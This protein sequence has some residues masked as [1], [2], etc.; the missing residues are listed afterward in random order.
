MLNKITKWVFYAFSFLLPLTFLP[1]KNFASFFDRKIFLAIFVF[2]LFGA[3]MIKSFASGG[4]K[5]PAGKT[6]KAV[7]AAAAAFFASAIFSGIF[8]ASFFGTLLQPDS[9][10]GFGLCFLIFFLSAAILENEKEVFKSIKFFIAG[11]SILAL[12]FLILGGLTLAGQAVLNFS[13]G[14]L[15]QV[16][17]LVFGGGL[18]ALIAVSTLGEGNIFNSEAKDKKILN[19][20]LLSLEGILLAAAI[21]FVD[22][23]LTW[24]LIIMASIVILC[25]L[26]I[27]PSSKTSRIIVSGVFIAALFLFFFGLPFKAQFDY[28]NLPNGSLSLKVAQGTLMESPKNFFF[29]SGMASFPNQFALHNGGALNGTIFSGIIFEQSAFGFLTLLVE[30]GILGAIAFLILAGVFLWH[31]FKLMT[32]SDE[33]ER[34]TLVAFAIAYYFILIFFFFW[35][36]LGLLALAFWALGMFAAAEKQKEIVF[37]DKP[38]LKKTGAALIALAGLTISVFAIFVSFQQYRANLAAREANENYSQG[39]ADK[40]IMQ[41]RKA[42]SLWP[43][44]DYY[45]LLSNL[46]LQKA[47]DFLEE[48]EGE[49]EL[50]EEDQSSLLGIA[51]QAIAVA[52]LACELNPK[53]TSNWH[54]LGSVYGNLVFAVENAGQAG[55]DAYNKAAELYPQSL[56]AVLGRAF[57]YEAR[58]EKEKAIEEYKKYLSLI[59]FDSQE[60]ETAAIKIE[61]L[62]QAE[63]SSA[64]LNFSDENLEEPD[65][66]GGTDLPDSAASAGSEK[67]E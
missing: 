26:L 51:D 32:T 11:A 5:Y 64:E 9:F 18:T 38:E 6:S 31:G 30:T 16:L 59:P 52:G 28:P 34:P 53:K 15:A 33:N 49:A 58:G 10:F 21:S 27:S 43:Q 54:N 62:S 14:N 60:A 56:G 47:N 36:N 1:E 12:A 61:Q 46:Y 55:L 63:T 67:E 3:W 44:D 37:A 42:I 4:L 20:A 25:R 50:S 19:I 24:F 65:N 57:I 39:E 40:A 8:K 13:A 66:S 45:I 35:I 48:K 23:R 22:L 17:A 2:L 29:G 41:T 7:L